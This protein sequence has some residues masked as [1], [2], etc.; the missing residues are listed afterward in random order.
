M[1]LGQE[2]ADDLAER[3]RAPDDEPHRRVHPALH[4]RSGVIAC[5][6]LTWLML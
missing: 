3:D 5:R 6:R 1:T 4:P 2:A